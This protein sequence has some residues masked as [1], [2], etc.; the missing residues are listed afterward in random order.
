MHQVA[1]ASAE[2]SISQLARL[3]EHEHTIATKYPRVYSKTRKNMDY[4][5]FLNIFLNLEVQEF[6]G[7]CLGK[8]LKLSEYEC[9][10][11]V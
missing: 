10:M 9:T 1:I 8:Q 11:G 5:Y 7:S 6:I 2:S 4:F 3:L